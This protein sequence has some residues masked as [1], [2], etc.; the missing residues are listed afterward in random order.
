M[1]DEIL[2]NLTRE[3]G[4]YFPEGIAD[5]EARH[6]SPYGIIVSGWERRRNK[7]SYSVEIPANS[8]ATLTLPSNVEEFRTIELTAGTYRFHLTIK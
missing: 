7:V 4:L 1:F 8:T 6:R 3:K 5:F 2:S